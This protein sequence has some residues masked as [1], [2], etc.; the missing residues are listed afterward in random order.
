MT[1]FRCMRTFRV[2]SCSVYQERRS[3]SKYCVPK[4]SCKNE[5]SRSSFFV[6]C[7]RVSVQAGTTRNASPLYGTLPDF[8]PTTRAW[9][10]ADNLWQKD[11]L[12]VCCKRHRDLC[13]MT[14][15]S[16][17]AELYPCEDVHVCCLESSMRHPCADR[18]WSQVSQK[19]H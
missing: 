4:V 3:V 13:Q 14:Q 19:S 9:A 16:A 2:L 15:D 6:W 18:S 8:Q 12:L 5:I 11:C 1:V 7:D 10:H 17:D